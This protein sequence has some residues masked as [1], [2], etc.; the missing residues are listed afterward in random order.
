MNIAK[1]ILNNLQ[2]NLWEFGLNPSEWRLQFATTVASKKVNDR[3]ALKNIKIINNEDHRFY[4][5]AEA[6]I[7]ENKDSL[8]ANWQNLQVLGL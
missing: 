8:K 4:F 2:A 3:V 1:N 7:E 5:D 6:L